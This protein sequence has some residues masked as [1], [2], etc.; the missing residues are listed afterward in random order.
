MDMLEIERTN[1]EVVAK[2]I[3]EKPY[4]VIENK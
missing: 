1:T 2:I 3:K 4:M